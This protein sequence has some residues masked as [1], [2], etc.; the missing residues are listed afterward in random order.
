MPKKNSQVLR[1]DAWLFFLQH[2]PVAIAVFTPEKP[3]S[4]KSNYPLL[5]PDQERS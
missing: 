1:K 3:Q 4:P 2:T 5:P